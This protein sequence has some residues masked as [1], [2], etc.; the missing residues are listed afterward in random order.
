MAAYTHGLRA[1]W[2][3]GLLLAGSATALTLFTSA[4]P[5]FARELG[6]PPAILRAAGLADAMQSG[7]PTSPLTGTWTSVGNGDRVASIVRDGE[8][9]WSATV[10]G[11]LVRW[12]AGERASR[13]WLSP[14]DGLPSNDIRG[15]ALG[16]DGNLWLATAA[17]LVRFDTDAERVRDVLHPQTSP[18]MPASSVSAVALAADG[19]VW[20]G[21]E[22]IWDPARAHPL[23]DRGGPPGAFTPGGVARYY[24]VDGTWSDHAPAVVK[25]PA[26]SDP[27]LELRFEGVPSDNVTDLVIAEDGVLWVATRPYFLWDTASCSETPCLEDPSYWM[28]GGGGIA[29]MRD[30]V[31]R[32]WR[33]TRDADTSCYSENILDLAAGRE[34]RVWAGTFGRGILMLSGYTQTLSCESGQAFYTRPRDPEQ[35]GL[36]GNVVRAVSLDAQGRVWAAQGQGLDQGLGLARLDTKGTFGDSSS[37]LTPWNSDDEW[38]HYDIDN[39]PGATPLLVSA[40]DVSQAV[41]IALGTTDELRGDGDGLRLMASDLITP[42]WNTRRTAERGLPSNQIKGIAH[43]TARNTTW[44][45]TARRGLAR[46]EHDTGTWVHERAFIPQGIVART[47]RA[48][49]ASLERLQVNLPDMAAFEAALPGPERWIRVG[50][51]ATLYRVESYI[52]ERSGLGP[53]LEVAPPLVRNAPLDAP[54][55]RLSRGPAGDRASQ[56]AVRGD[57]GVWAGAFKDRFQAAGLDGSCEPLVDCWFEGGVGGR[58]PETGAWR[59]Y[60]PADSPLEQFDVATVEVDLAGRVWLGVSDLIA[61]GIGMAV[62]DPATGGWEVH[63]ISI[64]MP[65]GNGVADLSVDPLKGDMWSAHLPVER[66]VQRPGQPDEIVNAGGGISRY[67]GEAWQSWTKRDSRSRLTAAG[68]WGVFYSVLADRANDRIWAGGWDGSPRTVHWPSGRGADAVVNWC[69][70]D[71]CIPVG[72]A[73]ESWEDEGLVSSLALDA[74]GRVWAGTHRFNQGSIPA[75]GGIKLWDGE[76]WHELIPANTGLPTNQITILALEPELDAPEGGGGAAGGEGGAMWV[77]TWDR[78]AARYLDKPPEPATA[79]P[80]ASATPRVSATP[81]TAPATSTTPTATP[82][83]GIPTP[84]SATPIEPTP[85][86]PSPTPTLAARDC[87]ADDPR[88]RAML[89]FVVRGR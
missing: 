12:H 26:P 5:R 68:D 46:L 80:I 65:A 74:R 61:S 55:I 32:S 89:P 21:F 58:D 63:Q 56:I 19:S 25:D 43:D 38:Q 50:D 48:S 66:R 42:T 87:A 88:C 13:Q 49:G 60:Q 22:Q 10:G 52:P 27:D 69:P 77:G 86:A 31:W 7:P 3:A 79:T 73:H 64:N 8:A 45:A 78:G 24:P 23:E 34:G 16:A 57:G 40:L 17:G 28:L 75:L 2:I 36:R 6:A 67:D 54:I 41:S 62:H 20:V 39:V 14:Q 82:T 83:R 85:V 29:A 44:F 76:S 4:A 1:I 59:V 53:W 9:I 70:I 47:T 11:G 37:S 18:G 15:L 35:A 72:W 30:D 51:D 71:Q 84:P 81:T 33:P